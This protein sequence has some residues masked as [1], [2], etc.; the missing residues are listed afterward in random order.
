MELLLPGGIFL[1]RLELFQKKLLK[2][3]LSVPSNTADAAVYVLTGILPVE[4]R[5]HI[6][7]LTFF[8]NI[9]NQTENSIEKKLARRQCAVKNLT[10]NSWFVEI[11]K[12][13]WIYN[14]QDIEFYLDSPV[15]KFIWK[16]LVNRAVLS[17]WTEKIH[18]LKS[19]YGTL[20]YLN[21]ENS[22]LGKMHPL[23]QIACQSAHEITRIPV[24]MKI[25]TG[26]YILQTNRARFNAGSVKPLC[27]LCCQENET[28]E[29]FVLCCSILEDIRKPVLCQLAQEVFNISNKNWC[30]Y[31]VEDK[32]QIILDS[33]VLMSNRNVKIIDLSKIEFH[34]KRL[35]YLLHMNRYKCLKELASRSSRADDTHLI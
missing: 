16:N 2:Q 10:S 9:C 19:L 17:F 1:E 8:N 15:K 22:R 20:K 27:Q 31:S 23:L 4:A 13:L 11:K 26:T 35:L 12:I 5:I 3:I 30:E 24:K 6:K 28:L 32:L 7:A 33:T 34:T 29:H 14:L 21:C 18:S 25:L